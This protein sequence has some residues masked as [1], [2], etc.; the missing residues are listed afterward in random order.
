MAK[1]KMDT[2]K[3]G[4]WTFLLGI[5]IAVIAGL[6]GSYAQILATVLVVLGLVVGLLNI[7]SKEVNDFLIAAIALSVLAVS[8]GGLA[9]I[10]A[11]GTYLAAMVGY[12]ATFMA[13]AAL[14]VALKSIIESAKSPGK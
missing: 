10:P 7:S 12:I 8:S 2:Q 13:P 9:L 4:G 11:V 6:V 5:S 3:I 14:V 1:M